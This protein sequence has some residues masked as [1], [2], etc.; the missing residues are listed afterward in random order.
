MLFNT[1][2]IVG[3]AVFVGSP[4]FFFHA[5]GPT[6]IA[7]VVAVSIVVLFDLSYPFS[8]S[9]TVSTHDLRSGPASLEQPL[10]KAMPLHPG[11]ERYK[12][13]ARLTDLGRCSAVSTI[14]LRPMNDEEYAEYRPRLA[15]DFADEMVEAGE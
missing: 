7:V 3:Y 9:V 14:R 6:A 11:Q 4:S 2:V 5:L 1:L 10:F 13:H 15:R 8:G 12:A